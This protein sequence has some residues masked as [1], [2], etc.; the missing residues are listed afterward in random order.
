MLGRITQSHANEHACPVADGLDQS[1]CLV[2]S[3]AATMA[4]PE[5]SVEIY[6]DAAGEISLMIIPPNVDDAFGPTLIVHKVALTFHLDQFH[7]DEYGSL[8]NY[9]N[10]DEV[11]DAMNGALRSVL[12]AP[13]RGTTLH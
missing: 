5:W 13:R 1:D 11:Q 9:I 8:G 6:T 4:A 10:R 2:L 3:I 7:W 12:A